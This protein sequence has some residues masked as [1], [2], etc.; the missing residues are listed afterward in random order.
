VLVASVEELLEEARRLDLSSTEG[1]FRL[2]DLFEA[3]RR[4]LPASTELLD[5][6]TIDLEVDRDVIME[7]WR[8]ASAFP[9]PTRR[10]GLPWASYVLVRWHP[11]R[12]RAGQSR[13]IGG[14]EPGAPTARTLGTLCGLPG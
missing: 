8:T 10:P 6:V 11:E 9:H 12:P 5:R 13:R 14:L 4:M 7:A 1:R 2:G 3:L